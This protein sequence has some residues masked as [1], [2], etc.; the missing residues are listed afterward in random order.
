MPAGLLFMPSLIPYGLRRIWSHPAHSSLW[1]KLHHSQLWLRYQIRK[2]LDLLPPDGRLIRWGPDRSLRIQLHPSSQLSQVCL[3]YA[4]PDWPSTSFLLRYLRRGDLCV[5]IGAN[6]GVYTLLMASIAGPEQVHSFECLPDNVR[7]LRHNL[8]LNDFE[9]VHVHPVA[10]A[11]GNGDWLLDLS[12]SDATA[13]LTPRGGPG[14]GGRL[15][16]PASR[17]DA[18][19][20]PQPLA[21]VKIDVEGA[22]R[23]VLEGASSLLDDCPPWVWSFECLGDSFEQEELLSLFRGF[24]YHLALFDPEAS[25]LVP[26]EKDEQGRYPLR[27]DDNSLAIHDTALAIVATRLCGLGCGR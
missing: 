18:F 13:S 9:A 21:Y 14:G 17:L 1:L 10:L 8:T 20:W 26:Y 11:N 27:Q 16:V 15:L 6:V 19:A 24:H 12:D 4:Q 7:K 3:Y 2:Q 23:L 22:E 5:D 25:R